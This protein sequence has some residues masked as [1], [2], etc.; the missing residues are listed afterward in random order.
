MNRE[1]ELNDVQEEKGQ[2][3][4]ISWACLLKRVFNLDLESC[5][6]CGG[7]IKVVAAIEDPL[8]IRKTLAHLGLSPHPPPRAPARYDPYDEADIYTHY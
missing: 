4:Y 1:N 7:Q 3:R 2:G 6:N 5:P 8:V